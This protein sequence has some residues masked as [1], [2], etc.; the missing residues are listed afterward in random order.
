M[1]GIVELTGSLAISGFSEA[2]L[3]SLAVVAG[4]GTVRMII[5]VAL[6]ILQ[7]V[8]LWFVFEKAKLPGWGAII[9]FYNIYLLFKLAG[10]PYWTRWIL[11]PPVLGILAII[12]QFN[13][14]EKF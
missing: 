5:G 3:L 8:A 14:A 13:I 7:I 10:H 12:A 1:D 2:D 4:F 6:G 9:P 11:F